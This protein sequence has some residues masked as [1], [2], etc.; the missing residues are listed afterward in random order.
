MLLR[1]L[2]ERIETDAVDPTDGALTDSDE[3]GE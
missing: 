2:G 3:T 1:W